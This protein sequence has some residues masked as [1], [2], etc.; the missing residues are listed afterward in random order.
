MQQQEAPCSWG[1]LSIL[2]QKAFKK[3][4]P[5]IA[6]KIVHYAANIVTMQQYSSL[7]QI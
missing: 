7:Q 1:N 4:L 5:L 6:A 3:R 2:G